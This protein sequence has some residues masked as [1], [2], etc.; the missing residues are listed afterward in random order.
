MCPA[1]VSRGGRSKV[2]GNRDQ[3]F[4]VPRIGGGKPFIVNVA[5]YTED[6]GAGIGPFT[7]SVFVSNAIDRGYATSILEAASKKAGCYVNGNSVYLRP[8]QTIVVDDLS[9][10]GLPLPDSNDPEFD[11]DI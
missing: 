1:E 9:V 11:E 3:E 6:F 10:R 2:I 5:G 7:A 4:R 8:G